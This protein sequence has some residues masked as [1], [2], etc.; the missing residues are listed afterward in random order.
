MASS[1]RISICPAGCRINRDYARRGWA[2]KTKGKGRELLV[3]KP[4]HKG[5]ENTLLDRGVIRRGLEGV[6][7]RCERLSDAPSVTNSGRPGSL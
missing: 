6:Q 1:P 3:R 2:A 5:H 4:T 7:R